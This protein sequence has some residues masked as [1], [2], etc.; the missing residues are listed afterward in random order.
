MTTTTD[1]IVTESTATTDS[2]LDWS[3][4]TPDIPGIGGQIKQ[5]PEDFTVEEIPAY[6][7]SGEGE[8]LFLWIEKQ[9]VSAEKLLSHLAD[10]LRCPQKNIGTAGMKDRFAITRQYVSI[11]VKYE[12]KLSQVE[13]D[14]IRILNTNRHNNKLK[15]GHSRGNRF[16]ILVRQPIEQAAD[17]ARQLFD[18]FE[19]QGFPNYF[20]N[21]RF[22]YNGETYQLGFQLLKAEKKPSSIPHAKRRFLLRLA[23]SAAQSFL[24]NQMLD[25]RVSA[26][27]FRSVILGDVM[28]VTASGG[29]FTAE[30]LLIITEQ[31]RYEN[32]E[33]VITGPMYGPKMK[34]AYGEPAQWE[35]ELL[36]H[37]GLTIEAFEKYS[38][39]ASG[40]RRP[41]SARPE[42]VNITTEADG[43]RLEF[44]LPKGVYATSLLRELMK[45]DV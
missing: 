30:D 23:L 45:E 43:L 13:T 4:L 8:H 44:S 1:D 18:S 2:P 38:N 9:D 16:S 19:Q 20:G 42:D 41:Y 36:N 17:I 31:F 27:I 7:P 33:T 35:A 26:G 14:S 24:F 28:Q 3:Y 10:S 22:G 11:P 21:Q 6:L 34:V 15:T 39:L 37:H 12:E 5:N 40:T 32:K 29:L 25:F